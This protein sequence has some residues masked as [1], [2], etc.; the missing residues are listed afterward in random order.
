VVWLHY[1]VDSLATS[2]CLL[3]P[4][5]PDEF[6]TVNHTGSV[7]TNFPIDFGE[8]GYISFNDETSPNFFGDQITLPQYLKGDIE[9]TQEQDEGMEL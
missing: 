9:K 6:E 5:E 8:T 7:I 3:P 4:D 2:H 1:G